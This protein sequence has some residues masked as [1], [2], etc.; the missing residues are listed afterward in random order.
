MS[1]YQEIIALIKE[2]G[3]SKERLARA[4]TDLCKKHGIKEIP[5]DY[6]ILMHAPDEDVERIRPFLLSKPQRSISGVAPIAIFAKP[7]KC[8][9]GTCTYCPGGR[10][11]VFG[12]VPQAY[13]GF[14][15]ATRRAIRNLYDPYLQV[16][17]RLE[18]YF[19]LGHTPEK[20]DLII[21]GGTFPAF[22]PRYK[23]QFIMEAYKAMNDFSKQ[24]FENG[25]LKRNEFIAFFELPHNIHTDERVTRI[26]KKL[27]EMKEQDAKTLEEEQEENEFAAIRCIGLTIETRPDNAQLLHANE[28][29]TWGATRVEV[30]VQT[31]YDDVLER[32]KR[33]QTVKDAIDTTKILKNLGF[34]INYH[35]M[36]GL[37]GVSREQ[38]LASLKRIF[39]DPDFRPD[40]VKVY[41]TLVMR[42][43]ELYD[44]WKAGKFIP[45]RA[46]EAAEMIAEF[47]K[48]VPEWVRIMRVQRDIP[49]D[50]TEDGVDKTNLR[51]LVLEVQKKK[52]IVCRCIR[53]RELGRASNLI[54]THEL[55]V[56]EYDA[57]GGKEFFL[58]AEQEDK[59]IGFCRLRFPDQS[60]RPEITLDSAIIRE[61]HVYGEA[62]PLGKTGAVQHK[63]IGK[64][65]MA[66]A[67]E[68]ARNAGKKKVIVISGVGVREYYRKLGYERE[69]PYMVKSLDE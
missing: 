11:S 26:H 56:Q 9:H 42:G 12:D 25:K 55:K 8:P 49:V 69:G 2:E 41:P 24:F 65:L 50:M 5:T 13:T 47:K 4:K 7:S 54:S 21:M 39:E 17:N 43:T 27:L 60:L 35:M 46:E 33:K 23:N 14:E 64:E 30:G 53:C 29:L 59:L 3:P 18:Q 66:K 32:I 22:P 57:S 20:V 37:P 10:G 44:D 58:S 16:M 51:Q 62:T 38:D 34:K 31:T 63:G 28:M 36:P 61:V 67:E 40:M 1:Y 45:I 48:S 19:V 68:I 15:P 52:G 6:E